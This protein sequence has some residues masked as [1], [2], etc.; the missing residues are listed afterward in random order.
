LVRCESCENSNEIEVFDVRGACCLET[1]G[2]GEKLKGLSP[3]EV[4]EVV[5]DKSMKE[6]AKKIAERENCEVTEVVDEG[7]VTRLKTRKKVGA[8][9]AAERK[10]ENCMVCGSALEYITTAVEVVCNYCNKKETAY[11]FCPKGHYVCEVCHGKGAFEAIKGIAISTDLKDPLAIAEIMMTHP[12]IPMLGCEHS[13]LATAA[14]MAA[15]KN[16]G[17]LGVIDEQIT[18]AMD[19]TRKISISGFCALA[20]SCGIAMGLAA[21]FSVITGADCSKDKETSIVLHAMAAATEAIANESGPCCCKSFVRTVLGVGY[22]LA[23]LH[24]GVDLP[25]HREKISCIYFKRHPHGC[26]ASKCDYF[27]KKAS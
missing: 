12:S 21:A 17:K 1:A 8:K 5:M 2:L 11:V 18:E 3:G 14:F 15:L 27:P 10:M 13:Y 24:L 25:I 20:G 26:R 22:N 9:E 7:E 23:K 4:L 6:M 19:R 16:H